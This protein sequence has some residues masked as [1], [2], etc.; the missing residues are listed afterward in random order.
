MTTHF[1]ISIPGRDPTM[2]CEMC[3]RKMIDDQARREIAETVIRSSTAKARA[4]EIPTSLYDKTLFDFESTSPTITKA[5]NSIRTWVDNAK[6]GKMCPSIVMVGGIGTG[7]SHLACAALRELCDHGLTGRYSTI[8]DLFRRIRSTWKSDCREPEASALEI[9]TQPEFLVLDEIGMQTSRD[10]GASSD[11]LRILGDVI[12]KRTWNW[13]PTIMITNL[14]FQELPQWVG[15]RVMSRMAENA[16][17][18]L[19]LVG[20]DFRKRKEPKAP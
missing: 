8:G 16:G 3:V 20:P 10:D 1:Q 7:K 6:A 12:D 5:W 4:A 13:R 11:D 17:M 2:V 18:V 14:T 19:P 9:F 15:E